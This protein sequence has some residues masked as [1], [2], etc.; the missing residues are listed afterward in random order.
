MLY[1]EFYKQKD[2]MCY[3]VFRQET[4][5]EEMKGGTKVLQV[6]LR[7]FV[8]NDRVQMYKLHI[9]IFYNIHCAVLETRL[10]ISIYNSS[11]SL[12]SAFSHS[13]MSNQKKE[14]VSSGRNNEDGEQNEGLASSYHLYWVGLTHTPACNKQ[15]AL[16]IPFLD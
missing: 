7:K 9:A 12:S 8:E 1:R 13:P 5:R 4:E 15:K 10:F 6:Q 2:D 3:Y 16:L 11:S 14:L